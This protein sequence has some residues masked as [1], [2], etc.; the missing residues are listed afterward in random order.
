MMS[1][2]WKFEYPS[3]ISKKKRLAVV[4]TL[5][6]AA[7]ETVEVDGGVLFRETERLLRPDHLRLLAFSLCHRLPGSR[8]SV[9][10]GNT[11]DLIWIPATK[12]KGEALSSVLQDLLNP[13]VVDPIARLWDAKRSPARIAPDNGPIVERFVQAFI[14]ERMEREGK[15]LGE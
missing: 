6:L 5:R 2:V 7:L 11:E 12:P 14:R 3:K 4:A 15:S 8:A 13:S 10:T 9:W 1:M